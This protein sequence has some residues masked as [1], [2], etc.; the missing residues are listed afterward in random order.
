M[1]IPVIMEK[2]RSCSCCV[3][4]TFK[5]KILGVKLKFV[6]NR[7]KKCTNNSR[8]TWIQKIYTF[9]YTSNVSVWYELCAKR[10]KVRVWSL[11]R[12]KLKSRKF[13]R[14]VWKWFQIIRFRI[15]HQKRK[16]CDNI[17][18]F[19]IIATRQNTWNLINVNRTQL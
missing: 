13:I 14:S 2:I 10:S 4:Q 6:V 11:Y 5:V 17:I 15:K 8:L 12:S 9:T 18:C 7:S 16:I 19:I 3:G 1:W